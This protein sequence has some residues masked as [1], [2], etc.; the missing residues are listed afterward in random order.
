M[1]Q[2]KTLK[3]WGTFIPIFFLSLVSWLVLWS[4]PA[5][6]EE[7]QINF[8]AE[9]ILPENQQSSVSYYDLKVSPG[10]TQEFK[11]RLKNVSDQPIKVRVDANNGL[12]NK[13]GALDYS[14]HGKKLLGSPTF[15]EL[16]SPSQTVELQGK[17]TKEVSFQLNIPKNGFEGTILGG[18]YCYELTD[19]KEKEIKG[20]SL[21]NKFAYTI[22]AKLVVENKKMEPAF[23]LTKVKPGLENGYLTLFATIEN[24]EPVLM[25]QLKMNA[26]VTKKGKSEK[27]REL[28]KQISVAPRSQFELPISWNDE[29][30]KKG[31]YE[32]TIQLED[33]NSKKWTL[34]KAFEIKGEDEKLNEEAVKITRPAS[35]ILL[36]FVIGSCILIILALFIYILKLRQNKS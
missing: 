30:L 15:E 11:L 7:N 36:Y 25:S 26:F 28:S 9:A 6:A 4:A 24:P 21:T 29:A 2:R 1:R 12:T 5:S 10:S 13:N 14:Q 32:L 16:I 19:G 31:L 17:E 22:G 34:K 35:N 20:F 18:F 33:Q 8:E 23:Q 3:R 27:I